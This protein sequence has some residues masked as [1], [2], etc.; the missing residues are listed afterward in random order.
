MLAAG[1]AAG[2]GLALLLGNKGLLGLL[3]G[4]VVVVELHFLAGYF[5]HDGVVAAEKLVVA[6]YQVAAHNEEQHPDGHGTHRPARFFP[7]RVN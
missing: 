3:Q 7:N 4:G 5:A 2:V 6:A 1:L